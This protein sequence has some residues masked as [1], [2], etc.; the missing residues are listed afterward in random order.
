M[1]TNQKSWGL[2][3]TDISLSD[4]DQTLSQRLERRADDLLRQ[5]S[6]MRQGV[7]FHGEHPSL[8]LEREAS[9]LK[10]ASTILKSKG[11]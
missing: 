5:A 9:D 2:T 8:S 11:L 10:L 7:T 1:M 3:D 6:H 4:I